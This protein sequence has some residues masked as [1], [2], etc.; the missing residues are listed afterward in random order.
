MAQGHG[1]EEI[2]HGAQEAKPRQE[3][4][5]E[6]RFRRPCPQGPASSDQA[7]LTS[8]TFNDNTATIPSSFKSPTWPGAHLNIN[9]NTYS[10]DPTLKGPTPM[11][12]VLRSSLSCP[13]H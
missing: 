4:A 3:L 6:L 13:P 5:K 9:Y 8:I 7:P 10:T 2:R 1:G 11:C 12:S